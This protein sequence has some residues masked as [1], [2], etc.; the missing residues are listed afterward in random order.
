MCIGKP[1][2]REE[3][4]APPWGKGKGHHGQI[5]STAARSVKRATGEG[6]GD[7]ATLCLSSEC[8]G[9][10]SLCPRLRPWTCGRKRAG[11]GR[12]RHGRGKEGRRSRG[13]AVAPSPASRRP[14]RVFRRCGR[15]A[16]ERALGREMLGARKE[17]FFSL[18][19]AV[20]AGFV[21]AISALNRPIVWTARIFPGQTLAQRRAGGPKAAGDH[22]CGQQKHRRGR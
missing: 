22:C 14:G 16:R 20:V 15:E 21:P 9:G 1:R 10:R 17:N 11:A 4:T 8:S 2:H 18:P 3:E 5:R 12:E 6:I 13:G 19:T 7:G